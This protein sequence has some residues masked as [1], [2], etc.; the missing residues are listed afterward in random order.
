[1]KFPEFNNI[2]NPSNDKCYNITTTNGL[3]TYVTFQEAKT[4]ANDKSSAIYWILPKGVLIIRTTCK[5]VVDTI[6]ARQEKVMVVETPT[7]Y[8]IYCKSNFY[9]TTANN[10]LACGVNADTLGYTSSD[11]TILLPFRSPSNTCNLYNGMSIV[12][13]N[14]IDSV[15]LWLCPLYN[16]SAKSKC[17]IDLPIQQNT[18]TVLLTHMFK[19]KSFNDGD[20]QNI[21]S[22]MNEH[23]AI[24]KLT[25][26]ELSSII[27]LSQAETADM[28]F[29]KNIF[30]HDAFGNYVIENCN[31]KRDSVT[32]QLYYYDSKHNI[33]VQ[34]KDYLMGYMTRLCPKLKDHQKE[35]AMKYIT[36][37]LYDDRVAF[38]QSDTT[39]CFKNGLYDVATGTFEPMTP[40]KLESIQIDA[41]YDPN[42]YS[43]TA[44]EFF[45]TATG[46]NKDC[47]QLLLEAIGYTML[48]TTEMQKTFMLIGAGRNGKSTYLDL[49]KHILGVRNYAAI[50]MKDL[51]NNFR[52][53]MLEGKLASIAADISAA[54]IQDTDL[55][56]NIVSGDE[57]TIEK[58]YQDA[59]L[60]KFFATMLFACNK[61]PKTTDNSNG[62]YRRWVI[63]PFNA[64][65]E[66]VSSVEGANFKKKLL[67]QE[68]IDYV[69]YKAV[70][71][72]SKVLNSTLE[73]TQPDVVKQMLE[74]YK[75]E[76][77]SVLSFIKESFPN[78]IDST[79]GA[80]F[81]QPLKDWSLQTIYE[82]YKQWCI[83]SGRKTVSKASL[84]TELKVSFNIEV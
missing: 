29:D 69:A 45:R 30:K 52:V 32:N 35:E 20:K 82:N 76:N 77:S 79:K 31:I 34:D 39:I 54:P 83:D 6:I 7:C 10:V 9:K 46:G 23:F 59:R 74:E 1:M 73:F 66:N 27:K 53:S 18:S 16:K 75:I 70:G 21:I 50:S 84:K 24:N 68:S 80:A 38:N 62:F 12:Y 55:F 65:L 47:E 22:I 42:A 26:N 17:G 58:K 14:G 15:P 72:I 81:G 43:A 11:T 71:A 63:V 56:K 36:N 49:L 48:K 5:A 28:F 67:A 44:D 2:V 64:N 78:G 13:D 61:L 8:E 3:M 4:L 60:G 41:N 33:Y 19:L 25:P 40:E 51:S 37:F 57:I